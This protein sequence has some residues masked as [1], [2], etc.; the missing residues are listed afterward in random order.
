MTHTSRRWLLSRSVVGVLC[1]LTLSSWAGDSDKNRATLSARAPIWTE[2]LGE[3]QL[4]QYTPEERAQMVRDY[5]TRARIESAIPLDIPT[6]DT[7]H[8]VPGST[9]NSA[10]TV[11]EGQ[12]EVLAE[13]VPPKIE[14]A[15]YAVT[16]YGRVN[17]KVLFRDAQDGRWYQCSGS[18]VNSSSKRLVATAAHCVHGGPGKTWH[19]NWTFIPN[20]SYGWQPYGEFTAV[21]FHVPHPGGWITYGATPAGFNYDVAFVVTNNNAAGQR[22]VDAVGGHGIVT[23]IGTYA[24]DAVLFGY[25]GNLAGGQNLQ[26]CEGTTYQYSSGGYSFNAISGCNFGPGSSGGPWLA[27]Y[28]NAAGLG[29]L[30]SVTSF[31]PYSGNSYI[32]GPYFNNY[33][34]QIFNTA[35]NAG[36]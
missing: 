33:I 22:V 5:W 6:A 26:A 10:S 28:N 19:Q 32:A 25:P 30:F 23:N 35:N 27:W 4:D 24:V 13:P 21:N 17:G 34:G 9:W 12:E 3:V 14:H 1:S 8:F 16:N 18:A 31:G 20:Y 2:A 15:P 7:A 11:Q 29:Y 36:L